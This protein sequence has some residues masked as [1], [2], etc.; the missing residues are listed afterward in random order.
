[1]PASDRP[2]RRRWTPAVLATGTLLLTALVLPAADATPQHPATSTPTAAKTVLEKPRKT[3]HQERCV[4]G[5]LVCVAV[6]VHSRWSGYPTERNLRV[7]THVDV[8][9]YKGFKKTR[10]Y[11]ARWVYKRPGGRVHTSSWQ[12]ATNYRDTAI[13]MWST[14]I[15]VRKGGRVCGQ[16]KSHRTR[17][18]VTLR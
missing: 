16:M 17:A 18:C 1:M 12:R 6:T 10:T 9:R 4:R 2:G 8:R 7:V 5:R 15:D 11:H 3:R 13:K 14:E